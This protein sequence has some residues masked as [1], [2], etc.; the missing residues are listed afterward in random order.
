M[1][2]ELDYVGEAGLEELLLEEDEAGL[3]FDSRE[4]PIAFI[5][6]ILH[7]KHVQSFHEKVLHNELQVT[8]RTSTPC[9]KCR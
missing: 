6:E 1:G 7:I 9:S 5:F 8:Q 4:H 2:A 3:L